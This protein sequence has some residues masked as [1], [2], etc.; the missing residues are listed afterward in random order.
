[1]KHHAPRMSF[2]NI[3]LAHWGRVMHI[4]VSKL[5]KIGSTLAP[6]RRH[7]IIWS[8]DAIL[9]IRTFRTN[10]SIIIS[11]IHVFSFQKMH[12]NKSS[13]KW[14]HFCHSL[15]VLN[16]THRRTRLCPGISNTNYT[17]IRLHSVVCDNQIT[18][19]IAQFA[20]RGVRACRGAHFSPFFSRTQNWD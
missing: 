10:F 7:V 1:M 8:N 9:L 4:C 2:Y 18:N 20:L 19:E 15:Y 13:A 3:N 16:I 5:T 6:T 14:R 12:L 17:P 11:E